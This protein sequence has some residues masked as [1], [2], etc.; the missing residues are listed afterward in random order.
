MDLNLQFE[1]HLNPLSHNNNHQ[2]VQLFNNEA[3]G[4]PE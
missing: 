4:F 2:A 1:K 3:T